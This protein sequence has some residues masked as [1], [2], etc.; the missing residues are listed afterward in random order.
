M[1][2]NMK[3]VKPRRVPTADAGRAE[4]EEA[5]ALEYR[6][7]ELLMACEGMAIGMT[8]EFEYEVWG[9]LRFAPGADM[10][11]LSAVRGDLREAVRLA[12]VAAHELQMPWLAHVAAHELQMPWLV[13]VRTRN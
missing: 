11:R 7:G 10:V 8:D 6:L 1:A 9:K 5:Y 4:F 2:K 13:Q 3:K 12:H